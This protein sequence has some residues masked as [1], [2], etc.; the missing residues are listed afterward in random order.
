[1]DIRK[2]LRNV[3]DKYGYDAIYIRRDKRF[4]CECYSERSGGQ[5]RTD[6]PNCFGTGFVT[7]IEKV[8]TRRTISSVPESLVRARKNFEIGNLSAKAYVYYL[9]H[10]INPKE[11]DLL[12]EAEWKNGVPLSI[13][14]KNVIS[15]ADPQRGNKGRTE[16]YQIYSYFE[17]VRES[18]QNAISYN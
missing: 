2:D 10:D 13:L 5:S 8:R 6:C 14:E 1:M 18:D 11:G 16:F 17:P 12:I 3:L 9:E 4:R 15:I 7:N